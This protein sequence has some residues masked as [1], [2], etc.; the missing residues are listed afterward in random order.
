MIYYDL[1]NNPN[2]IMEV[3]PETESYQFHIRYI[4]GL[5]YVTISD[6]EGNRISGPIRVCNG[7]WLIPYMAYSP[8]G[9]GNFR[10]V[11]DE[12]QY[13][14]FERFSTHC[15]LEYYSLSELFE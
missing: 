4:R 9:G 10:I 7:E 1:P 6:M 11:D 13:P 8:Q 14:N 2:Y 3:M 15:R 5:M 12:G